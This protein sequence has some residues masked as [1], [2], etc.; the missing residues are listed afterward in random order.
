MKR[1]IRLT[2]AKMEVGKPVENCR[3][4]NKF[5]NGDPV[6]KNSKTKKAF[7]RDIWMTSR[8]QKLELRRIQE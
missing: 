1:R 7:Q 4:T 6:T 2:H 5:L 3:S 8:I